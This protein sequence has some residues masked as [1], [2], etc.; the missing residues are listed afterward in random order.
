MRSDRIKQGF[1]RAPHR[2]LLKAT[3]VT[4]A[5]MR[6]PFIAV[7]NSY[8]DIIPGQT[9]GR[10]SGGSRGLSVGHV[11]PGAAAGGPLAAVQDGD[12]IS[13]D[14]VERRIDIDVPDDELRRRLAEI[15][16]FRGTFPSKWLRR[17]SSMVSS[18]S[19]GAVLLE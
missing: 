17:Y 13:I 1:E 18:A 9:D 5:D 15:T 8:I 6:K 12:I 19:E 4:D 2:A 10:F 3:G 11:S 16:E 7:C 14:L